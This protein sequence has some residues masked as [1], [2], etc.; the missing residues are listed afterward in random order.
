[1]KSYF[2]HGKENSFDVLKKGQGKLKE[3]NT[4]HLMEA[5]RNVW[6]HFHLRQCV[7]LMKKEN[8]LETYQ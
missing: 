5:K 1:M 3:F 6:G 4:G 7:S 2:E 8:V